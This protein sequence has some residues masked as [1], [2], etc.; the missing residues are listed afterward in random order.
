M[1]EYLTKRLRDLIGISFILSI[2]IKSAFAVEW[3]DPCLR[4]LKIMPRDPMVKASSYQGLNMLS[5]YNE[6]DNLSINV[7]YSGIDAGSTPQYEVF[8][9]NNPGINVVLG[10]M[11]LDNEL[12]YTFNKYTDGIS[13][14]RPAGK[15]EGNILPYNQAFVNQ[16]NTTNSSYFI[17]FGIQGG[18][19]NNPFTIGATGEIITNPADY[20]EYE[21]TNYFF[22]STYASDY[23]NTGDTNMDK[24]QSYLVKPDFGQSVT[25]P[26]RRFNLKIRVHTQYYYADE[27]NPILRIYVTGHHHNTSLGEDWNW[28]KECN[29]TGDPTP[30]NE[31]EYQIGTSYGDWFTLIADDEEYYREPMDE[32]YNYYIEWNTPIQLAFEA[33]GDADNAI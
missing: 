12:N 21:L 17:E 10:T 7:V 24:W 29:F 27:G 25:S 20:A 9:A 19:C 13:L 16:L 28:I 5:D 1:F 14:C 2:L 30:D 22:A 11:F 4:F 3:T 23:T 18:Y 6:L 31:C 32:Y 15:W 26:Y 8:G 33:F